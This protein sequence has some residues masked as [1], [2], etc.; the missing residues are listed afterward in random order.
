VP[1]RARSDT[2]TSDTAFPDAATYEERLRPPLWMWTVSWFL[3]LTFAVAVLFTAGEI[4][5]ALAL[6][7]PGIAVTVGFLRSTPRVA[8]ADGELVAGRAHIPVELLGPPEA[9]DATAAR[10]LRGPGADPMAYHLIRP[11]GLTAVRVGVV[12]RNDP[13]PYWYVATRRPDRLAGALREAQRR[14]ATPP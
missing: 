8:V 12:D 2:S 7:I 13:T 5:G 1:P 10:Y 4:A 9:L 3:V 11:W 6:T 14:G